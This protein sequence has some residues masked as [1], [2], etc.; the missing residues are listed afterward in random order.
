M[1]PKE[2]CE[3][4]LNSILPIAEKLLEKNGEF[5]PVG[6]VLKS[7][8]TTAM[9]SVFD[10]AEFPDSNAV[11]DGLIEAHRKSALNGEIKVSGIA[12]NGS[13]STEGKARDA[14]I[15]SLEHKSGYSVIVGRTYKIGMFKKIRF[16]EI[17]AQSGRHDVFNPAD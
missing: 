6:A 7:D 15:V 14:I 16:G 17:F 4:L 10:G 5:Y 13:V 2:D 8:D 12:W 3:I 1:T 9:T 11:I